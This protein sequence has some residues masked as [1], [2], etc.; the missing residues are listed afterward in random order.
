MRQN[1][2]IPAAL[3]WGSKDANFTNLRF[4]AVANG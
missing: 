1:S 3:A 4:R 2:I